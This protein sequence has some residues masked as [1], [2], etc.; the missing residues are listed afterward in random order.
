M[1]ILTELRRS[2]VDT[3]V[4]FTFLDL[5][6]NV[7]AFRFEFSFG[8]VIRFSL[9]SQF[10]VIVFIGIQITACGGYVF[11]KFLIKTCYKTNWK[12]DFLCSKSK[13]V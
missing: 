6:L 2:F 12:E 3:I 13:M 7:V 11:V 8:I 1:L 9:F 10:R 4:P 5:L